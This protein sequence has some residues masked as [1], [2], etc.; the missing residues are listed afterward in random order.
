MGLR[1]LASRTRGRGRASRPSAAPPARRA[2]GPLRDGLQFAWRMFLPGVLDFQADHN[3]NLN[4]MTRTART[5]LSLIPCC[6]ERSVPRVGVDALVP[7]S[8][9]VTDVC[10]LG[11]PG[12]RLTA[13]HRP[14]G[15]ASIIIIMSTATGS[16]SATRQTE[17]PG[18]DIRPQ[19]FCC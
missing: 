12:H 15:F 18:P 10:Q 16:G 6:V 3:L 19:N 17:D 8:L 9:D 5:P 7:G 11:P 1:G 2:P 13:S 14:L 4:I